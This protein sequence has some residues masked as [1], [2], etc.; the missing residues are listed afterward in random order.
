M[1][2]VEKRYFGQCVLDIATPS[3]TAVSVTDGNRTW[4]GTTPTK[5]TVPG[6][7]KYTVTIGADSQEVF[8]GYGEYKKIS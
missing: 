7:C 8:C 2:Y 3:G 6:T 5:I 4:T 1:G